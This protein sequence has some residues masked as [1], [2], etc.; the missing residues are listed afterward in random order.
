MGGGTRLAPNGK[1]ENASVTKMKA[2]DSGYAV[3]RAAAPSLPGRDR[4]SARERAEKGDSTMKPRVFMTLIAVLALAVGA[5]SAADIG[6]T[7]VLYPEGK[8]IKVPMAGTHRA[9]AAE[10]AA[11]VRHQSGQSTITVE[12]KNLVP[13][14]LFGGDYVSYVLWSVASDGTVENLGGI[15]NIEDKGT[16]VYSSPKRAFAFMVTAEPIATVRNPS[17]LVVFTS[18]VPADKDA[19]PSAFTFGGLQPREGLITRE[20]DSI[21]GQTYKKGEVALPLI[22]AGKAV[23]LMD[24][25]EAK[26]HDA[27]SYGQAM[28]SFREAQEEKKGKKMED[29]SMRAIEMA[30]QA[31]VET[32]GQRQAQ[33]EATRQ[34]RARDEQAAL[35]TQTAGL[36]REVESA[37]AELETMGTKLT[38]TEAE[39]AKTRSELGKMQA[40]RVRLSQ[41]YAALSQQLSGALGQMASATKTD[42]GY[43]VSLSGGAFPSGKSTLTTDAKYVLAKLSGMLLVFPDMKLDIGGHTDSTGK[44]DLNLRLSQERAAAVKTFLTE[45][46]V[47]SARVLAQGYGPDQPVAPNDTPEGR[48]K[49]RRV[50]IKMTEVQ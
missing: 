25:F 13:A 16:A 23:E 33:E 42:S 32:F 29:A 41:Q 34:A 7:S 39:L 24:R 14:V 46:G 19:K 31:L 18:G 10:I 4:C 37:S 3:P 49:N 40:D 26:Q 47:E 38:R 15:A 30:G 5:A 48:S 20:R 9:P 50:D 17:D 12:Y 36:Q 2:V 27:D 44:A 43:L 6:L 22:Q 28:A 35:T 8:T 21:A 45:M 1:T 11:E